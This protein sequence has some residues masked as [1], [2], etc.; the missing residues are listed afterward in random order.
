MVGRALW[1]VEAN[2]LRKCEASTKNAKTMIQGKSRWKTPTP[3]PSKTRRNKSKTHKEHLKKS[4]VF[5]AT[6]G[7]SSPASPGLRSPP[8]PPADRRTCAASWALRALRASRFALRE[9]QRTKL[10]VGVGNVSPGLINPWLI[11][12]GVGVYHFWREHPPNDGTG[13]LILG[14]H[15]P[16]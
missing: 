2:P 9:V 11:N 16:F 15:Y 12:R 5:R 10:L 6:P 14:Q 7:S 4:S 8:W 13:L 1:I 3:P